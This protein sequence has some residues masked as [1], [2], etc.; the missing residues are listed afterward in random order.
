VK[1]RISE[2][3]KLETDEDFDRFEQSVRRSIKGRDES[4]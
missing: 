3:E 2:L 1:K 4:E